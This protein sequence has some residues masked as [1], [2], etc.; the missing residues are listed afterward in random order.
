M[1]NSDDGKSRSYD[2]DFSNTDTELNSDTEKNDNTV[3]ITHLGKKSFFLGSAAIQVKDSEESSKYQNAPGS[4]TFEAFLGSSRSSSPS[5]KDRFSTQISAYNFS[6]SD[7]DVVFPGDSP[8]SEGEH[9]ADGTLENKLQRDGTL[10]S[11]TSNSQVSRNSSVRF[12]A[13]P[14]VITQ[15]IKDPAIQKWDSFSKKSIL[16]EST[17]TPVSS[18]TEKIDIVS[19]A[20]SG[21][22]F[23][24]V[25]NNSNDRFVSVTGNLEEPTYMSNRNFQK[26][27]EILTEMSQY[28]IDNYTKFYENNTSPN[29]SNDDYIMS[30]KSS[31]ASNLNPFLSRTSFSHN[32]SPQS[33]KQSQQSLPHSVYENH[34]S[35]SGSLSLEKSSSSSPTVSQ[36]PLPSKKTN[37]YAILMCISLTCLIAVVAI[38]IPFIVILSRGSESTVMNYFNHASPEGKRQTL[39]RILAEYFNS[40]M[41]NDDMNKTLENEKQANPIMPVNRPKLKNLQPSFNM[42]I[43]SHS[44]LNDTD[45]SA[46]ISN[47]STSHIGFDGL[48]YTPQG[49]LYPKCEV[50][51]KDVVLDLITISKVTQRIKTSGVQCKQ[52]RFIIEAIQLFKIDLKLS[53]GVLITK[54]NDFNKEQIKEV[55]Y[56]L[57]NYPSESIES[58][59]VGN[60]V[61]YRN[62]TDK[63][64]LL[65]YIGQLKSK[66]A[67]KSLNISVGTSELGGLM[68]TELI[69]ASDII[70]A[71]I[72]PF[73]TGQV[74][75]TSADW[76]FDY[77]KN[78][79]N[80]SVKDYPAKKVVITE[81]GWPYIGGKHKKAV[82]G[83]K[84]CQKF[85][86]DFVCKSKDK[87]ISYYY[88]GAFD[89][90]WKKI[91]YK[92]NN[93]WQTEWGIFTSE[94]A[95]KPS[96]ELPQ[97]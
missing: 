53:V 8:A 65:Q 56:I 80:K 71:N 63:D 1:Q 68:S 31:V 20:P 47:S 82:A 46:A 67:E 35:S 55:E 23:D 66:V 15:G 25:G 30:L 95:L 7:Q 70:G 75:Q 69:E 72:Y 44:L 32:T 59:F 50:T 93:K 86:S 27:Q 16:K 6:P 24:S 14:V 45:I 64:T 48:N 10:R 88:F 42:S 49:I 57:D 13:N 79:L 54:N 73:F 77:Q 61:L 90:P 9:Y 19:K 85:M 92:D 2:N 84:H 43:L 3:K 21:L 81:V 51:G 11:R 94:R 78:E 34:E 29:G 26:S 18:N 87:N 52:I 12:S 5:K 96:L 38:V 4:S 41:T 97:C 62:I 58:I 83:P 89:D 40:S 39:D 28:N 37:T 76:V 22:S 36:K 91:Y 74:V 60:E 17:A 33:T